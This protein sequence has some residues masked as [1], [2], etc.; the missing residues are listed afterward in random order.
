MSTPRPPRIIDGVAEAAPSRNDR[1]YAL[2][3][4]R[5]LR[6]RSGQIVR[7]SQAFR[8]VCFFRATLPD[9]PETLRRM[10]KSRAGVPIRR[11]IWPPAK[12]TGLPARAWPVAGWGDRFTSYLSSF[13]GVIYQRRLARGAMF[14]T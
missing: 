1:V 8:P 10:G 14:S 4:D 5:R 12:A 6:R 3:N 11:I 7:M 13:Y 2:R 9:G